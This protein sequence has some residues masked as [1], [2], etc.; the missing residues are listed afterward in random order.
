MPPLHNLV[1]GSAAATGET[2]SIDDTA[3]ARHLYIIGQ[4]GTGK[5]GLIENLAA[6]DIKRGGGL[7]FIDPHGD[8]AKRLLRHIPPARRGD[9]INIDLADLTQPVALNFMTGVAVDRR[10][11]AAE[12][13]L[14]AFK[15]VYGDS[16][17]PRMEYILRCSIR[18]LMDS[19]LTLLAL[20]RLLSDTDFRERIVERTHDTI[21]WNF[22]RHEF[23][24]FQKKFGS[25]AIAPIQNKIGS[26]LAM[27]HLRAILAQQT[28]TVLLRDIMDQR[29]IL[30]VSLQKGRIGQEPAHLFGALLVSALAQTAFSRADLAEDQRV[31]FALYCDEFQN[32][33]TSSFALILSESRK[34]RLMLTLAHQGS[35]QVPKEILDTVLANCG[36][37]LSFR[38]GPDDARLMARTFDV[39]S[40]QAFQ[41]LPNFQAWLRPLI[42]GVP[43]SALRLS[44]Q[45]PPRP[46][47]DDAQLLIHQSRRR[48][49]TDY[50]VIEQHVLQFYR[51]S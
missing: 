30:I 41:N 9:L 43:G 39:Q 24:E 31:P 50:K 16:W 1:L 33:A 18:S 48:Y 40:P 2:V 3:R 26:V 46:L 29:K 19:E 15:H 45:P 11:A 6:Q 22:W 23:P 37:F 51:R 36:T 12:N 35:A 21:V 13:I 27:P 7:C 5:S 14:S 34:Y 38:L 20:P 10:A 28:N 25:E 32:F 47:H 49:G 17:G 4:T 8:T 42:N 44:T